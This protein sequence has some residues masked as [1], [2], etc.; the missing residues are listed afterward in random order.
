MSFEHASRAAFQ[1]AMQDPTLVAITADYAAKMNRRV[2]SYEYLS[3][4]T[5]NSVQSK[6]YHVED[7]Y[8]FMQLHADLYQ[9]KLALASIYIGEAP[10]FD[11]ENADNNQA[12]SR[13][14]YPFA[15]DFVAQVGSG[16]NDDGTFE[17]RE[18]IVMQVVSED[19]T[20]LYDEVLVRPNTISLEVGRTSGWRTLLHVRQHG[21]VARWPYGSKSIYVLYRIEQADV[22]GPAGTYSNTIDAWAHQLRPC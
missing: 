12:L 11:R 8:F 1:E 10:Y 2:W 7:A 21:A 22:I 5:Q 4:F 14:W 6:V 18:P 15:A 17:W 9:R 16:A 19:K 13:L 20:G 3:I